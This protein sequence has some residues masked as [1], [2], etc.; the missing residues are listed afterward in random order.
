MKIFTLWTWILL[1]CGIIQFKT[2]TA[3]DSST[4]IHKAA[5]TVNAIPLFFG[6]VNIFGE[7]KAT[8]SSSIGIGFNYWA[9]KKGSLIF[10]DFDQRYLSLTLEWRFYLQ[11]EALKGFYVAPYL[12][13][14]EVKQ[15][16]V[17]NYKSDATGANSIAMP[18]QNQ[19]WN[20]M[21]FGLVVGYQLPFWKHFV[22]GGFGGLGYYPFQ[23]VKTQNESWIE[24]K[25]RASRV[26]L[27][28]G[29]TVGFS[30]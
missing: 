30:F 18:P 25:S 24:D 11:G 23:Q 14:R 15:F 3:Q 13:V 28:L 5:I 22:A 9:P 7:L 26:D 2:V 20:Q 19:T 8:T 29:A 1:F 17:I 10:N 27:R 6:S 21:G 4:P 16:D 12:K